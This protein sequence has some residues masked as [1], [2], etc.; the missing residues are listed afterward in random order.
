MVGQTRISVENI[1]RKRT[2]INLERYGGFQSSIKR[3]SDLNPRIK[4]F[5]KYNCKNERYHNGDGIQN[6]RY[7]GKI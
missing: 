3:R 6:F 2:F 4:R 5:T 7:N 1:G